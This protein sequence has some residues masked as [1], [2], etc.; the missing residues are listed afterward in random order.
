LCVGKRC[1][2][3]LR[4]ACGSIPLSLADW[5]KLIT[6][7][8]RRPARSDPANS[9]F[10]RPSAIGRIWFS[11]QLLSR[12]RRHRR[13]QDGFAG[14][15]R[16]CELDALTGVRRHFE[17][18]CSA[19]TP[20]PTASL[21]S[22]PCPL[23]AGATSCARPFAARR[24]PRRAPTVR[25]GNRKMVTQAAASGVAFPPRFG[26]RGERHATQSI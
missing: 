26:S 20:P 21:S 17:P 8:A 5:I 14:R 24:V 11:T 3:S 7:A 4:Y 9:Q 16:R 15:L 19:T 22:R 25:G 2:T 18:T 1:S 13:S 12:L 23:E 10:E 6:A